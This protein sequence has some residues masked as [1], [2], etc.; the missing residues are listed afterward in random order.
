VTF[1]VEIG[2]K[3]R[4]TKWPTEIK[5][6]LS[7]KTFG[8]TAN[9]CSVT[10]YEELTTNQ[11]GSLLEIT[12]S[13]SV[14]C[15]ITARVFVGQRSLVVLTVVLETISKCCTKTKINQEVYY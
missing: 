15:W 13:V 6:G 7:N 14:A 1:K 8:D 5:K 2:I 3:A 12:T 11:D 10:N 4:P 9:R